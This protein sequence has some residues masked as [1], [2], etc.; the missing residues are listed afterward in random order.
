LL[1]CRLELQHKELSAHLSKVS[2]SYEN[3][4]D[5]QSNAE[6]RTSR[7]ETVKQTQTNLETRANVLLRKLLTIN[8]PQTSEAE[9]KWFKELARVKG[10]LDGPRGLLGEARA[11]IA[12]GKRLLELAGRRAG[13]DDE[14]GIG[15]KKKLDSKVMDA[16]EEAYGPLV[17][18]F[19]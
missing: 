12:E 13:N 19:S 4:K 2:A 10:R 1:I 8:A 6:S 7:L 15:G 11:R 18:S 9:D 17:F 16:I 3:V 14:E 5:L